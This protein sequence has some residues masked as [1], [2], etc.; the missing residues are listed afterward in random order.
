[1]NHDPEKHCCPSGKTPC[2]LDLAPGEERPID[3]A[4]VLL[5]GGCQNERGEF[6]VR[7]PQV[8]RVPVQP[9]PDG[10]PRELCQRSCPACGHQQSW[11]ES[12]RRDEAAPLLESTDAAPQPGA[13]NPARDS[14]S[15]MRK[16]RAAKQ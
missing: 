4:D 11:T 5:M 14:A 7:G 3:E 1:M 6:V 16:K 8:A 2:P 13:R 10:Q 15:C 9:G 12:A